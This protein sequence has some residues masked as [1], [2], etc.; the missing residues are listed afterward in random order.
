MSVHATG[1]RYVHLSNLT[2]RNVS[3]FI[4]FTAGATDA[5]G[6]E[7]TCQYT[8]QVEGM[9]IYLTSPHGTS[10]SLSYSPR[11]LLTLTGTRLRVSTRYRWKVCTSI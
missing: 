6:N 5:D 11:E 7:A 2:A 3:Q 9:Y 10:V 8:L 1:G 4:V